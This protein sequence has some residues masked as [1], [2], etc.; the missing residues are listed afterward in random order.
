[1]RVRISAA[2]ATAALICVPAAS[3][4]AT[5]PSTLRA[6]GDGSVMVTPDVASLSLT[7]SRSS[8]SSKVALSDANRTIR[9]VVAAIRAAGVPAAGIQTASI[10][11]F[12]GTVVV[13]TAGHRRRVRRFIATE[14]LSATSKTPIVGHV[15]DAAVHAGTTRIDGPQFS[16]SDPSAGALAAT[17]AALRDAR[18]RADAAAA[19]IGYAITGVESVDL[20][21]QSSPGV[22]QG[23]AG[24]SASPSTPLRTPT[25][26]HPGTQEV[27]APGAGP[28]VKSTN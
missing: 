22:V 20:S 8:T 24:S 19:A 15:I 18:R 6:E 25:T 27:D 10:N 14:I 13:G 3:A 12:R 11:V 26:V 1:M 16:F 17:N 5:T 21:P 4:D 28:G 2:V 7:V 9:A 23:S